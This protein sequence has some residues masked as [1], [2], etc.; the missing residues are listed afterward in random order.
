MKKQALKPV[1]FALLVALG[2]AACEKDPATEPNPNPLPPQQQLP[3]P[4]PANALVSK[5]KWTDTDYY[6]FIYNTQN[7]VS[8]L[9]FQWQ[10]VE[11]DPTQI[12]SLD[13][14]FQY[15][16][17][18]K[19]I[20]I[21]YSGGFS[22]RFF[23]HGDL[24]H[25]TKEFY[26]GG[27]LAKEVTYIY[28]DNRIKQEVWHVSGLPGEPVDVYKYEF[29]Y[30]VK[31]NLAKIE[32]FE[33]VTD[34]TSGQQQYKLRETLEYSD[35]DNKINPISWMLRYPYLPQVRWQYNNPRQE[36]R[37]PVDGVVQTTTH[38][39]QYNSEGL[40]VLRQTTTA[41]GVQTVT[42]QY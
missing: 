13:Y 34:S 23:Y 33:Q 22:T 1:L 25:R 5:L 24:V 17:Q 27:A 4:L 12:R 42:Y 6:D 3:N 7:Q 41:S 30:D 16:A 40:P 15:D 19:P 9:H 8:F 38:A 21:N 35:F 31:G 26:P 10:F 2:T 29:G 11:G 37:R 18:H 28:A 14:D 39:Y 32:T 20:Q 36:V